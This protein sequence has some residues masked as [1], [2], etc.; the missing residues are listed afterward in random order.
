[1]KG[2][3]LILEDNLAFIFKKSDVNSRADK[4]AIALMITHL[5]H[6]HCVDVTPREIIMVEDILKISKQNYIGLMIDDS[7]NE[8]RLKII[9]LTERKLTEI[10]K[11]VHELATLEERS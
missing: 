4:Q 6:T 8:P 3:L 9:D 1:M 7:T 2:E 11:M 10:K 5:Y